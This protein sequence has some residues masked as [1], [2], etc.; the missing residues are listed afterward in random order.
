MTIFNSKDYSVF[1]QLIWL[2]LAQMFVNER[3]K[4][5]DFKIPLH[6]A[7]GHEAIAVAVDQ[8]MKNNDCLMLT[9]RNIHY[10]LS[11]MKTLKED[12]DE[13]YL[14]YSGIAG[15]K[16]G[17]M[18]M[19]NPQK[20]IFYTSSILANNLSV[21][22]GYALGNKVKKNDAIEKARYVKL[23]LFFKNK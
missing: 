3:Y 7:F 13:Y 18:N 16:Q 9:H 21:A 11:R 20:G 4:K 8:S 19:T 17:S 15:G 10:N 23:I 2:R 14:K 5:G 22:T 1:E 6:L 12:L